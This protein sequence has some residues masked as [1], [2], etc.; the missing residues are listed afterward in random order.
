MNRERNQGKLKDPYVG[1]FVV[2]QPKTQHGKNRVSEY[3]FIFKVTK[4]VTGS[5]TRYQVTSKDKHYQRWI[6]KR[7]DKHFDFILKTDFDTKG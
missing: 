2:L 3:G 6:Q 1:R 7:D 5:H 4:V